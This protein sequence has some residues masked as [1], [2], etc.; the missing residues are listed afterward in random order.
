[1]KKILLL[2]VFSLVILSVTA[3]IKVNS[4]GYVGINN[5]AP[6]Y[7]LDV[8]GK[9]RVNDAGNSLIFDYGKLYETGFYWSS[10]GD[11]SNRWDYLY[12]RSA[13]FTF[14]PS[15]DSDENFKT[16]IRTFSSV[17]DKVNQLRA[18]KYKL[19]PDRI[20]QKEGRPEKN[21]GDLYGFIAQEVLTVFPDIVTTR[22][23]GTHG[24]RYT[25]LIPVLVKAFQEQQQEI[26][27]LKA[28]I[29]VLESSKNK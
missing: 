19:T 22:E 3:Q 14:S 25:E 27:D 24:I 28:R 26:I 12:V 15:I 29:E 11:D 6:S 18:V 7:R 8:S 16:D 20:P 21:D 23:N 17:S 13:T 1:M 9:F 5:T 4:S 2:A 10:L